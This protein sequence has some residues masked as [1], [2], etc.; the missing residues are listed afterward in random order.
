MINCFVTVN[1][2]YGIVSKTRRNLS[3]S[4]EKKRHKQK[5]LKMTEKKLDRNMKI[6]WSFRWQGIAQ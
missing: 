5:R 3:A 2:V 4:N 6:M 1:A